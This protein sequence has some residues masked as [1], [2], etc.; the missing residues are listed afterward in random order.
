[1]VHDNAELTGI[2][3]R[4]VQELNALIEVNARIT[5]HLGLEP[6]LQTVVGAARDLVGADMGGL[7]VLDP[8]DSGRYEF[9]KV[10]GWPGPAGFPEGRGIFALPHKTGQ[11]LRV[12][13][14]HEHPASV[15]TPPGHPPVGAFLAVP[16]AMR[17]RMLGSLFLAHRPGGAVFTAEDE[18]FLM[19]FSAQAAIAIENARLYAKAEEL[20]VLQERTR[21]S[22]RL[23]DSVSQIFF[24]L[25]IEVERALRPLPDR[26]DDPLRESLMRI[27]KLVAQGASEIRAAIFSL[28]DDTGV[29]RLPSDA[30]TDLVNRFEQESGI[31]TS[32]ATRGSLDMMPKPLVPCA[33]KIIAESLNNIRRHSGSPVAFVSVSF[34]GDLLSVSVQDVGRGISDDALAELT[35]PTAHYG[36]HAMRSLVEEFGGTLAVFRNDEGGTTVRAQLPRSPTA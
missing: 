14:L 13:S 16:L 35:G 29:S 33:R 24:A 34:D 30:L 22:Q 26:G 1:M 7:L 6:L 27:K 18:E 23:H 28:A 25:G 2:L 32:L 10:S 21:I 36:L 8:E 4:K 15:G 11:P 12:R 17:D 31:K 20:A 9:F 19:A 5:S 3:R